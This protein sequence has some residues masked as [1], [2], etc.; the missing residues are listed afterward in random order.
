MRFMSADEPALGILI[1]ILL[2]IQHQIITA[3]PGWNALPHSITTEA[4]VFLA[5]ALEAAD[6]EVV[7]LREGKEATPPVLQHSPQGEILGTQREVVRPRAKLRADGLSN[8]QEMFLDLA[9]S[10]S[11]QQREEEE[12]SL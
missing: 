8:V 11:S 6:S 1:F 9:A 7:R 10:T 12:P 2:E 5:D 3:L 4:I